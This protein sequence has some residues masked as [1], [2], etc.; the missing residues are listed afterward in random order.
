MQDDEHYISAY[1]KFLVKDWHGAIEDF[2][3]LISKYP[4]DEYGYDLRGVTFLQIHEYEK[5][6]SD[7]NKAIEV[8]SRYDEAFLH[9]ASTHLKPI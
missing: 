7:F 8:N 4:D 1:A 5:A 6:L 3:I 2:S 9:R